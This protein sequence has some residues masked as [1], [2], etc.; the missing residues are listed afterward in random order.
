MTR[1]G[2][3][4]LI[5][6]FFQAEDGIRDYKV[7]GVQTCALPIS[8]MRVASCTTWLF[9]RTNPS[10]VNTNP[11]PLPGTSRA[12]RPRRSTLC[13]TSTL[14]TAGPTPSAAPDTFREHQSSHTSSRRG[15]ERGAGGGGPHLSPATS[16]RGA[17]LD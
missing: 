1:D 10:G 2:V 16:A 12:G 5:F 9:V 4:L 17:L 8:S 11:E 13:R 15:G 7:T 3:R 14:T 6:F